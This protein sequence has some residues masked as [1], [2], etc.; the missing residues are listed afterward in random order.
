M[1]KYIVGAI[2]LFAIFSFVPDKAEA[3]V[4][5]MVADSY[6]EEGVNT[7]V[8]V[9]LETLGDCP[10]GT[11]SGSFLIEDCTEMFV[12]VFPSP[13]QM[14]IYADQPGGFPFQIP[15]SAI[16]S[17]DENYL[18]VVTPTD[19][20]SGFTFEQCLNPNVIDGSGLS[21]YNYSDPDSPNGFMVSHFFYNSLGNDQAFT[22]PDD[23]PL[24]SGVGIPILLVSPLGYLIYKRKKK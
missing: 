21:G 12:Y 17:I 8:N 11:F 14:D 2:A 20:C 3:Q 24:T 7:D 10:F 9:F 16:S 13:L 5:Y 4:S 18:I 23:F 1:K 22:V 15:L 19:A 6:V